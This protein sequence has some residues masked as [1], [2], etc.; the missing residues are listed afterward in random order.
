MVCFAVSRVCGHTQL[1]HFSLLSSVQ[2]LQLVCIFT[3]LVS[4]I[5]LDVLTHHITLSKA[6]QKF[7][8]KPWDGQSGRE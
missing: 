6:F 3:E 2:F 1:F 8:K 4:K 7:S 5:L